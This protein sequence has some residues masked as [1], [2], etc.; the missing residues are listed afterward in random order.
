MVPSWPW[1]Y[2]SEF[3]ILCG[4]IRALNNARRGRGTRGKAVEFRTGLGNDRILLA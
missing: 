4:S 1:R 3:T 2:T